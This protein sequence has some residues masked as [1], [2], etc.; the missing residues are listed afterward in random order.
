MSTIKI[1]TCPRSGSNY[2]QNLIVNATGKHIDFSHIADKSINTIIT[3]ARDPFDSM[4]S[5]LTMRKH[6]HPDVTFSNEDTLYYK[7]LYN[8]LYENANIVINYKDLIEQPD[9]VIKNICSLLGFN[10][11]SRKNLVE[12]VPDNKEYSYLRSSKISPEY[13][14]EHFTMDDI[15]ECYEPY[16]R[17]LSR[18]IDLTNI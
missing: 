15:I 8:F 7:Y 10:Q 3:V 9:K 11:V 13:L 16:N 5:H 17:L 18:A 1:I 6:Y 2:L 14:N 4:H 12:L